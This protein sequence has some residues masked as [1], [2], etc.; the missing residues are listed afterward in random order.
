MKSLHDQSLDVCRKALSHATGADG[1]LWNWRFSE[2][3][4][5]QGWRLVVVTWDLP[6]GADAPIYAP[7]P[8]ESESFMYPYPS[9]IAPAWWNV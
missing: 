2:A 6:L 9:V 4:K 1:T 8:M 7:Q 3:I 5:K